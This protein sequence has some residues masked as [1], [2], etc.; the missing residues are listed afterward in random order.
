MRKVPRPL[1]LVPLLSRPASLLSSFES[2]SS[3]VILPDGVTNK[4]VADVQE[5]LNGQDSYVQRGIPY[6]RGY[7]LSG[8]PGTGKS[9]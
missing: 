9:A 5:F 2:S 4:L 1:R 8:P 3:S 6:R 7:L